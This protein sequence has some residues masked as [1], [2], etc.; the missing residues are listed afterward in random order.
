MYDSIL[1]ALRRGAVAEALTAAE[2]LAAAR[3]DDPQAL[4]WLSAAQL[5]DGKT[6]AALASID[7]A[8]T[9]S[10]DN[11]DL[12]LARAGVLVGSRR[13]EE[14]QASLTQATGL[15]P[16]QFTAYVVQAQLALA[17]G[18]V[19]EAERLNR[20]AA[21]V[22]PDHPR[23]AFVD[24]MVRFQNGDAEGAL[25]VLADAVTRAPDDTQLLHALGSV[26]LARGHLAFAEQAFRNI[27]D[28]LPAATDVTLL[29]ASVIGRQGR[30]DEALEVL[31]PVMADPARATAGARSLAGRLHLQAGQL[32]QAAPLLQAALAGGV[33]DRML[34]SALLE[35][36]HRQGRRTEGMQAVDAC[37][38]FSP[39]NPDLWLAR[40][41]LEDVGSEAALD[42]TQRWMDAAPHEV[43][44][45]E[46]RLAALE[47]VGR[48]ED[49]DAI[50]E[51][52]IDVS[53]GHSAAQ[54]RKVNGLIARDPAAAVAHVE[55]LLSR[56]PG[57]AGRAMLL[58][59]LGMAQD[60][61]GQPAGAVESW[62]ARAVSHQVQSLPLPLL[63]FA[64]QA[65]P[66]LADVS[67]DVR[68]RPLFLWGA[69][70]S[71]V[72]RL[73]AVLAQARAAV[74]TDR[75]GT[76]PPKD[77]LQPFATVEQL[78]AGSADP[79]QVVADWRA[80][81]PA[82]G[83]PGGNVI[84]WLVWW[85]NTLLHALRPHLPQG[86]LLVALRD[87]RDMLLE[88]LAWGAPSMMAIPTVGVAATWLAGV[89][90]HLAV[91]LEEQA[92]PATVIRI[93]G[94]EQD[95]SRLAAALGEALGG[96]QLPVPAAAGGVGFE[97]GRWRA[98]AQA[99]AGPFA[100]LTPVAVRLGYPEA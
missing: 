59:W 4:R 68:E 53:P 54:A 78:L 76:T 37:L 51:R 58:G 87:P 22:A 5:Q 57:E 25:K 67:G 23:L 30:P 79:A 24:G 27:A 42:V 55:S 99:L 93:D 34:L 39:A 72:E 28:R 47:H 71:G 90:E 94:M 38:A 70:G 46:A 96:A 49:A 14:A 50:A 86:H 74:L 41:A 44:A 85:D 63:G 95:P 19:A 7:R 69:P 6:D 62:S 16:N 100:L 29:I 64:Q 31:A 77:S 66:A 75:F 33:Q 81:L 2:A 36:W 45:L 65:W 1:D 97:P 32:E 12:H 73:V 52:L 8:I 10:P 3:P 11:A 92:Y 82:R 15:D 61:A 91:L 18:D 48:G 17:R 43:R 13:T 89:L 80:A 56:A 21:R 26:Y 20:L 83:A 60:R 88:W 84:D 35:L 98:Y 9:L 40:L